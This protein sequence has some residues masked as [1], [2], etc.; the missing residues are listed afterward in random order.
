[1]QIAENL[2]LGYLIHE[3]PSTITT[4]PTHYTRPYIFIRQRLLT[5]KHSSTSSTRQAGG[6]R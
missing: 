2:S 1:M 5:W 6:K 3:A 4:H